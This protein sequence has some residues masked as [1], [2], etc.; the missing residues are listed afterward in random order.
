MDSTQE[1]LILL[2][3]NNKGSDKILLSYSMFSTIVN[4]GLVSIIAVFVTCKEL[5]AFR[6]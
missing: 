1:Y 5:R 2:N 4:Q 6:G 3:I